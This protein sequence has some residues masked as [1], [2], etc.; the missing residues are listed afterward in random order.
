MEII[1][2]VNTCFQT[3]ERDMKDLERE[4]KKY[5]CRLEIAEKEKTL[6]K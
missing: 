3:K 1:S 6:C 4:I 2:M 5:E